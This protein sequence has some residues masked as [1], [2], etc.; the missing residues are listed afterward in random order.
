MP[1]TNNNKF[2][3]HIDDERQNVEQNLDR[4]SEEEQESKLNNIHTH[5]NS[6]VFILFQS[7]LYCWRAIYKTRK[8]QEVIS[9]TV[10]SNYI[11]NFFMSKRT[12]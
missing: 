8:P 9:K 4:I 12:I 6:R 11:F 5:I 3:E 1:D 7:G 2:A 10:T